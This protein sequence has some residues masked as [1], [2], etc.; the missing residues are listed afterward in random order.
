MEHYEKIQAAVKTAFGDFSLTEVKLAVSDDPTWDGCLVQMAMVANNQD[1][2][3]S[4]IELA[5]DPDCVGLYYDIVAYGRNSDEGTEVELSKALSTLSDGDQRN[6]DRQILAI[7]KM[8]KDSDLLKPAEDDPW[9]L[10]W[11]TA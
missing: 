11:F 2:L 5:Q 8:F 3:V 10:V 1:A 4:K 6:L 7:I 9:T